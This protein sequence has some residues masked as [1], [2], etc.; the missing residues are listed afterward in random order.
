MCA[1]SRC[2]ASS[3]PRTLG[4]MLIVA[5]IGVPLVLAYTAYVYWVFRGK[6]DAAHDGY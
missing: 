2:A 5:L 1:A 6:A 3:T 4:V